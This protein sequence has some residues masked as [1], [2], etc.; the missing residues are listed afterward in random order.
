ME[1]DCC[2][3]VLESKRSVLSVVFSVADIQGFSVQVTEVERCW[4]IRLDGLIQLLQLLLRPV[5]TLLS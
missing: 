5:S 4:C 3:Y 2:V 1:S